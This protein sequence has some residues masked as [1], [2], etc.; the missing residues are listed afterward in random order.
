M[1]G[2]KCE[3]VSARVRVRG[4]ECEGASARVR[5]RGCECQADPCIK[6]PEKSQTRKYRV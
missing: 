2:C 1:R 6:E 4:C 5:V 3:G